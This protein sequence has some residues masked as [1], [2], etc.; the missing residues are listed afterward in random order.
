MIIN[1]SFVPLIELICARKDM[2][3]CF[4]VNVR[5]TQRALTAAFQTDERSVSEV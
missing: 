2:Y 3:P 5:Q 4:P 1:F